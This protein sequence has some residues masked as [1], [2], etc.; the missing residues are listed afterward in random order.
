[1]PVYKTGSMVHDCSRTEYM[2]LIDRLYFPV[3][4]SNGSPNQFTIKF[5]TRWRCVNGELEYMGQIRRSRALPEN[6]FP[7]PE[8]DGFHGPVLA[9]QVSLHKSACS[10]KFHPSCPYDFEIYF[11]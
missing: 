4:L 2:T 5:R 6:L 11:R 1:M 10:K 7:R 3:G 8:T 9:V